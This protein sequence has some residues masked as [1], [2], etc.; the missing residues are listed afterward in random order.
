MPDTFTQTG[1]GKL[2]I[3]NGIDPAL[4][5]DSFS[6][7]LANAGI[8]APEDPITSIAGGGTGSLNG[9]YFAYVTYVRDDGLESSL[10]PISAGFILTNHA[11]ITY[12]G[13]PISP[14]PRTRLRRIYRN[15]DGQARTVYLDYEV[16]NNLTDLAISV[17]TDADLQAG[18]AFPLFDQQ[19]I[20]Q[21]FRYDPPPDTKPYAA[22]SGNRAFYAG[23]M[24]YAEGSCEVVTGTTTIQGRG[25]DWRTNWVGR[26]IYITNADRVY[27]IESV[28]RDTQVITLT[29]EYTGATNLFAAYAIRPPQVEAST[30]YYSEAGEPEHVS[31]LDAITVPDEDDE[32]TGLMPMYGFL[33]ILKRSSIYRFTSLQNPSR[34]GAIFLSTRRGCIN[35]RCAVVVDDTAFILDERG[36]W[37]FSGGQESQDVSESIKDY[38]RD[39]SDNVINWQASRFFHASHSPAES[40]IR[41]FVCLNG[42]YLPRDALCYSYTMN[43]WWTESYFRPI[44]CS[45]LGSRGRIASTWGK[46]G[47]TVFLGSD[48]NQIFA[49]S[50]ST[51]DVSASPTALPYAVTAASFC[52]VDIGGTATDD[53]VGASV[54]HRAQEVGSLQTRRIVAVSGS[55]LTVHPPWLRVPEVDDEIVVGGI[56]Y[57]YRSQFLRYT[58][59]ETLQE[60]SLEVFFNRNPGQKFDIEISHDEFGPLVAAANI[61]ATANFGVEYKKDRT[62]QRVDMGK[63]SAYAKID[64][65]GLREGN[66]D[67]RRTVAVALTGI[68][69]VKKDAF[70]QMVVKGAAA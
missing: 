59:S 48:A 8:E 4:V 7:N 22:W 29:E 40:A 41:F 20:P 45:V 55:T 60:R 9:D 33:Y 6:T 47:E 17:K 1:E 70:N 30:V 37:R 28:D 26:Q 5:W 52:T 32:I 35:Q 19:G 3:T 56:P 23:V 39:G 63:K 2:V 68:G 66:T 43:R 69:G 53:M 25:T 10:S 16:P 14:D 49:L 12:T 38:F 11:Q 57:Q 64:F 42:D 51:P 21:A 58:N 27:E 18:T 36:I 13:I 54:V 46:T 31:P 24:E 15:T 50:P 62:T 61:A 65:H 44:G 34:D 67:G